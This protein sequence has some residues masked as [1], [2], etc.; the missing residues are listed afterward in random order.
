MIGY[1]HAVAAGYDPQAGHVLWTN[2]IAET[3]ASD[4]PDTRRQETRASIFR[5]H[6]LSADRVEAL[7]E[8]AS[9]AS[10]GETDGERYRAAIRPFLDE[11]L[12]SELRRRDFGQ[13]LV[14]LDRLAAHN[15]DL[16][17]I[18]YYRGEV[19]RIRRGEGDAARAAQHYAA[20]IAYPD[21]PAA[22]WRE[23][24]EV[25]ARAGRNDSAAAYLR[26]YLD[27]APEAGDRAMVEARVTQ[28][29]GGGQ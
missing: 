20:A 18:E 5:T 16:G 11:W 1:D 24:G 4:N 19:N 9:Q 13:T 8:R 25:E 26:T 27:R 29:T 3:Q 22:A 17:V 7:T 21:A 12:R 15:E 23:L 2:L 6:P 14:V 10:G 28:L